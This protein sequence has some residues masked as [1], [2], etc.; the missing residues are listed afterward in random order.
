MAAR[1]LTFRWLLLLVILYAGFLRFFLLHDIP[2]G[3]YP[4]EAM[5]GVDALRALES[6]DFRVFYPDNNGREG[7]FMNLQAISISVFG[8]SPW[9]LRAVSAAAGTLTV[10]FFVLLARELGRYIWR[11]AERKSESFALLSGFLLAASAWHLMF[12]RIGFRA[13]L[14]PLL[15]SA[16][17]FFLLRALRDD[18]RRDMAYAAAATALSLYS[19]IASRMIPL[20]VAGFFAS[21]IVRR[22]KVLR[23]VLARWML[24][25]AVFAVT[26]MP[27]GGYFLE[28]PEDF[29]G[30]A[31]DVSIFATDHPLRAALS[32]AGKIALMFNIKGDGNWRHNVAGTPAFDFFT[33]IFFLI[34]IVTALHAIV[35]RKTL[36]ASAFF[37]LTWFALLLV[38]AL[39]TFEGM[40][41]ALRTLGVITPAILLAAWGGIALWN[42]GDTPRIPPPLRAGIAASILVLIALINFHRYFQVWAG[43]ENVPGAFRSDLVAAADLLNANADMTR[44]VIVNEIG[45]PLDGI[46]MPSATIR[47][48]TKNTDEVRYLTERRLNEISPEFDRTIILLTSPPSEELD[49][50]LRATFPS[51][52]RTEERGVTV[53]RL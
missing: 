4:D 7:L 15:S 21:D 40:P 13:I 50:S 37:L 19:Y 8:I 17:F 39:A 3:L 30:R 9:A 23:H 38:P 43:N 52:N 41:H 35:K 11:D 22:R 2:P 53:Y 44:Y 51:L 31:K 10:L 26:F 14:L 16:A 1:F 48:L 36:R 24:F 27:L 42:R 47:F 29:T 6:A 33:G 49:T 25:A 32:S 5:N 12:S 28:H 46:P 20:I 34:G 18:C 45:V